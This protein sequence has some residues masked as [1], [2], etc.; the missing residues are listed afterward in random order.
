YLVTCHMGFVILELMTIK[1]GLC[2]PIVLALD[3]IYLKIY[4]DFCCTLFP[5]IAFH[6]ILRQNC[7]Y[8]EEMFFFICGVLFIISTFATGKKL[9]KVGL[10]L[11]I[12][13]AL[14]D[15][16]ALV[17]SHEAQLIMEQSDR[18]CTCH[19]IAE[20]VYSKKINLLLQ[21]GDYSGFCCCTHAVRMTTRELN[22]MTIVAR[23]D[24]IPLNLTKAWL[25]CY[26][27]TNIEL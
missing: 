19:F 15:F 24:N 18:S 12:H 11:H 26:S 10:E 21:L 2:L 14:D 13:L 5:I 4:C 8:K 16:L 17:K 22:N 7:L 25:K 6:I 1:N 27:D 3:G 23:Q 20:A 9:W